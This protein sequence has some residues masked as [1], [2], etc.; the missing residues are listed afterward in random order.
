MK[1]GKITAKLRDAVPV[2]FMVEGKEVKRYKNIELPDELKELEIKD[3]KFHV[4][5]DEKIVFHLI[6][7]KGVLPEAFPTERPKMTRAVKAAE[8]AAMQAVPKPEAAAKPITGEAKPTAPV[9][10]PKAGTT[11]ESKPVALPAKP[12]VKAADPATKP[13]PE[14]TAA[15]GKDT[16]PIIPAAK[17]EAE[18]PVTKASTPVVS[19]PTPATAAATPAKDAK[20]GAPVK[21]GTK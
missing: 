2:C 21:E 9:T 11:P 4:P 18:K 16:K 12:E 13:V 7:D 6:F 20:P 5:Q 17:T 14:K 1:A 15:P 8:K 19:R 3:F 10:A